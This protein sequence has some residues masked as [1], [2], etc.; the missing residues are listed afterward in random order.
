MFVEELGGAGSAAAFDS[1]W[2]AIYD[3]ANADRVW[4]D[5]HGIPAAHAQDYCGDRGRVSHLRPIPPEVGAEPAAGGLRCPLQRCPGHSR[6]GATGAGPSGDPGA[7]TAAVKTAKREYRPMTGSSLTAPQEG[8]RH[9]TA[10]GG[11]WSS[12]P[13]SCEAGAGG[14]RGSSA[15][16]GG[17]CRC[18]RL[19]ACGTARLAQHRAGHGCVSSPTAQARAAALL[20]RGSLTTLIQGPGPGHPVSPRGAPLTFWGVP[21]Q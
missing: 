21:L 14:W 18:V 13:G 20:E 6:R 19:P 10:R 16:G 4:L 15:L 7:S 1:A 5:I 2:S 9:A 12:R 11:Y 3:A 8:L 17:T